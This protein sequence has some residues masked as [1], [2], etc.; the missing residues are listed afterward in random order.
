MSE[1]WE[2]ET[3]I[4]CSPNSHGM[5][6]TLDVC[7]PDNSYDGRMHI[8][9]ICKDLDSPT[10]IVCAAICP[11]EVRH[12]AEFFY[13]FDNTLDECILEAK[14]KKIAK[15][16]EELSALMKERERLNAELNGVTM[17]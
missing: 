15:I 12:L 4:G 6:L 14:R 8:N 13:K 3:I 9:L 7:D 1:K 16:D 2:S 17:A 10:D 5:R 11:S